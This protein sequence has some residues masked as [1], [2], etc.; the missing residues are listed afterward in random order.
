M[1]AGIW[2]SRYLA[3]AAKSSACRFDHL[4]IPLP[5]P[6]WFCSE[7]HMKISYDWLKQYIAVEETAQELA[8][9]LTATGLEVEGIERKVQIEGGLVGVVIGEVLEC[10][11]HPN[12]DKLRI[13]QTDI[14][15]DAPVQIV[16]GAPNV[17]AGQ[18]VVV[19][20]VGCTLY[21]VSGEP[22]KIKKSKIRGEVSMGM[23]C[24]EDEIGLGASHDGIMVL[25][26]DLPNGTP[27][28]N[29]F[30]LGEDYLIEIGL[31]PNRVDAASHWGVCRDLRAVTGRAMRFPDLSGFREGRADHP[32]RVEVN[33]PEACPRYCGLTI[34]GVTVRESPDWLKQRLLSIGLTPIN[35]VVDITNFVLHGLG[36]P[37]HAFDADQIAGGKVVVRTCEAGTTFTTLDGVERKLTAHDL[38]ICDAEKPMCI[39]GVFGGIASGVTEQT[40]SLFLESAYFHPGS[41]RRTAMHHGLK[42]DASFRFERGTDPN[43]AVDAL[44]YAALLI[45]ELAGGAVV[46]P[47]TDHYPDPIRPAT[48]PV[49][50]ATIHSLIGKNIPQAEIKTILERLDIRVEAQTDEQFTVSVPPYRVDVTRPA[51]I[52]EEV[53][54]IYGFNNVETSAQIGSSFLASFPRVDSHKVRERVTRALAAQGAYE[55]MT[56]SITASRHAEQQDWINSEETIHIANKLTADLDI[57]RQTL[58]LS[59]LE[60]IAH[61]INRRQK[62]LKLFEFG[63]VYQ[64]T[65]NG[66]AE[67]WQLALFITGAQLPESWQQPTSKVHF[68]NVKA[69]VTSVLELL[70]IEGYQTKDLSGGPFAY[71]LE[72]QRGKDTFFQV[73]LLNPS[74]AKYMDVKQEVFC[75]IG[76]WEWLLRQVG[77]TTRY[78]EIPKFPEVRRDL[79]L[80]IDKSVTFRE[81]EAIARK[82]ERKLLQEVNVF[83][84]YEGKNLGDD[85]KKS[86]SVSFTL[87]DKD[88]TLNDKVIDKTMSRL[89]AAYEKEVGAVIRR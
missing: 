19:A 10:I 69:L 79:S 71:G 36:Q 18:K 45:T 14:G 62:D 66:T 5:L 87:L 63:K 40:T 70:G 41:V 34:Q 7:R 68:H 86:Y 85:T 80:V 83:D 49:K 67:T 57:M 74:V 48:F 26:T 22:F 73:G 72:Y 89:I 12:A 27:A 21:P 43:M 33:N 6:F 28:A 23:I 59:G 37:L 17:A 20:T 32:I 60:V 38:M 81:L 50:W 3:G 13:T 78:Q 46:S 54:R 56:N 25:E 52:V 11:T 30:D 35:N 55:I 61:N 58:V 42:T 2:S 24:A 47:I 8:D 65:E 64:K 82:T 77:K 76:D 39:A 84:V 15:A 1:E 88:K 75:A 16:C 53:L 4:P 29:Y 51:D 31:T 44:K 9:K